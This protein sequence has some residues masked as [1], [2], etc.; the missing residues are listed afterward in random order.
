MTK[1]LAIQKEV[2]PLVKKAESLVIESPKDMS[3]ASEMRTTLKK[4]ANTIKTEKDKVMRPLLD[5]VSAERN[6]WSEAEKT[7]DTALKMTDR[8]MIDYQ[9]EQQRIADEEAEKIAARVGEGKGKLKPETASTKIAELDKPE[10]FVQASVGG[11][12]FRPEARCEAEDITQIPFEYLVP[13]MVKIRA[14]MKN[15]IQIPGV[16]YFTEQIPVNVRN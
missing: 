11:T 9:T 2:S 6:R 14:A 3:K 12:K 10:T 5:A 8:K 15:G 4:M 13:D 16:R 1:E 7:I